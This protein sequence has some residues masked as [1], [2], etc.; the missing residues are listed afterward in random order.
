MKSISAVITV[1]LILIITVSLVAF[2]YMW[3]T[4]M[5][6]SLGKGASTQTETFT[7]K[8]GAS[9]EID[10]VSQ[11]SNTIYVRNTGNTKLENIV[12]YIN[13]KTDNITIDP[14][15]VE[16]GNIFSIKYEKY[17]PER[18]DQQQIKSNSWKSSI[19]FS[20]Q[21]FKSN[22]TG[23]LTNISLQM[24]DEYVFRPNSKLGIYSNTKENTV[25]DLID[26]QIGIIKKVGWNNYTFYEGIFLKSGEKYWMCL[27]NDDGWALHLRNSYENGFAFT[28]NKYYDNI[29]FTFK[30]YVKELD[31]IKGKTIKITTPLYQLEKIIE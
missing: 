3:I 7:Q 27:T 30:T 14:Q 5:F 28:N 17:L 12:V 16:P 13:E 10:S 19:S 18:L 4:G 20:C 26:Q 9:F 8:A 31:T 24:E 25:G 11:D 22:V 29:D 1:V 23:L 2:G 6:S 21:Q 15:I